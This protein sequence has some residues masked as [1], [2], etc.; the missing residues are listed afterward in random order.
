[1]PFTVFRPL[2]PGMKTLHFLLAL[3][4]GI[5]A[6]HL[7][8]AQS[9]TAHHRAIYSQINQQEKSLQRVT[10]THRDD[11]LVF[12]LTGWM[13]KG[14]LRKI[15]AKSNEDGAGAEEYYLENE[16]PLFVYSTY[17]RNHL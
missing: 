12:E 13:E 16:K 5:G 17:L 9:D 6:P 3:A 8:H 11:P 2:L 7:A 14:V 1:M 4:A 15:V 10:G